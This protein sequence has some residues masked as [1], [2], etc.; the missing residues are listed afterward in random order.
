[1]SLEKFFCPDSV[2]VIGASRE[3]GK[4][5]RTV[6]ESIIDS[7]FKGKIYPINPKCDEI[8]G[9]K[10]YKSIL[11]V[12]GD[13]DLVVIV[14]P[15][16][17]VLNVMDECHKKNVKAAIIISAGFKETGKAG[18]ELEKELVKKAK[19]YH[20]RVLG[21]NCLGMI[22]TTCPINASFSPGMPYEG[23]IAFISQSGALGTAVLDWAKQD[24]IGI[25]KFISLGN[26]AD[27]KVSEIYD[28]LVNEDSCKVITTYIEGVTSGK[29]F[30]DIATK[31]ARKKPIILIKSGHTEAGAK[32]A[33]SH[34][35][36]LAGSNEVFF[37]SLKQA[38]IIRAKTIKNLFDY[39][40]ALA[41]QP[42]P[43]GEK[44]AII[45]N[46]GGPGIMA[47]DAIEENS[48]KLAVLDNDTVNK[49]KEFLPSSSNFNNPVDVLGDAL[50]DRFEKTLEVMV[51]DKNIDALLIILTPQAMTLALET[52]K[53]IVSVLKNNNV[54]IP[55]LTCFMGGGAV[56]DA[57]KY[58]A[59]N[60]IP[61]F[62]IPEGAVGTLKV[63]VEYAEWLRKDVPE[64]KRIDVD[65][66]TVKNVFKNA[67][68]ENKLEIGESQ[69]R[70][71]LEAYK[72]AL[73]EALT[74]KTPEE[75]KKIA[76]DIGYPLVIKIDSPDILHKTDV[77][78]IKV[79]VKNEIDLIESFNAIITSVKKHKPDANIRGISIQEMIELKK[80][81]IIGVTNDRF[82]GPMIML[83][84]GGI[85][86]EVLKD[87]S[88]RIAPVNKD[89]CMEMI[90]EIKTSKLLK[91]F[92]GEKPS[93]INSI[94]DVL[95]K[96]SQLVMDFPEIAEMD[97]NP[98]FV[99]EEGKGSIA[100]D[101]RIRIV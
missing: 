98:L 36:S 20:I 85:Y 39:A 71:I 48:M 2:A 17:Y 43:K 77:G 86:V 9:I 88:F 40:T 52:A 1:M 18:A 69:A 53:S 60:Q 16:K 68:K 28:Y 47:T 72:I 62:D 50:P 56:I 32:A 37:T 82:F 97:I 84:F 93:D 79:G 45:T 14:I 19:E 73:P 27:I 51:Q 15:A 75:A 3:E 61:N 89:E 90:D 44:I 74:A 96:V 67:R 46:A 63:M 49:L 11:D 38:G 21:P 23:G 58:F 59:E 70:N 13:V 8:E 101:V 7:K 6:L 41:W 99:K 92:R 81:V 78:G 35:G 24:G 22:N 76:N 100:G 65:M 91:G 5:G 55:V 94:V 25:S 10:C 87:V 42:L 57:K 31:V 80:E 26:K 30:F 34:T 54:D 66:E 83:G 29:K 12:E 4:V 33:S 95:L 64:I